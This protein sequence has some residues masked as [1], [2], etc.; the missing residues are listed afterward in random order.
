MY[1]GCDVGVTLSHIKLSLKKIKAAQ[2]GRATQYNHY[3]TTCL[4]LTLRDGNFITHPHTSQANYVVHTK[5][6]MNQ[7]LEIKKHYHH[8]RQTKTDR[9]QWCLSH[10]TVVSCQIHQQPKM[11]KRINFLD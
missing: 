10:N 3:A 11:A 8:L 7:L 6:A 9:K 1:R 2:E 5:V 4:H